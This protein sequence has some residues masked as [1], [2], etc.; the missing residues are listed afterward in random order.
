MSIVYKV[1]VFS[2]CR[3]ILSRIYLLLNVESL[4]LRKCIFL[5]R[6]THVPK[7]HSRDKHGGTAVQ[8]VKESPMPA[9]AQF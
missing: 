4:I 8:V 3:A 1:N 7:I 6:H 2:P 5:L 9:N